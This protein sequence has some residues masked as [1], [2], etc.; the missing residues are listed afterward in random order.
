VCTKSSTQVGG[1]CVSDCTGGAATC[2]TGTSCKP[3]W[4]DGK[5]GCLGSGSI[6][7]CASA[8]ATGNTCNYCGTNTYFT[9]QCN[10]ASGSYTCPANGTCAGNK[11]CNCA[12]GFAA[13]NCSNTLCSSIGGCQAPNWWCK[14][15]TNPTPTCNDASATTSETCQC[16]DGRSI[17]LCALATGS[18]EYFCSTGCDVVQQGCPVASGKCTLL[19]DTTTNTVV[20]GCAPPLNAGTGTEGASCTRAS[21]N[22]T[23]VGHDDCAKGFFCTQIGSP[24]GALKC[25]KLCHSVSNCSAG[26]R[27]FARDGRTP[28]D[29]TCVATCNLFQACTNGLQC[30]SVAIDT[31]TVTW[32]PICRTAGAN[33]LGM[34]CNADAD[35]AAGMFCGHNHASPTINVCTPLCDNSHACPATYS[36]VPLTGLPNGGGYC[37]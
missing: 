13:V 22:A 29:G 27:C 7:A 35:C 4:H 11:T 34:G 10:D 12:T 16:T 31:D 9:V 6:A 33:T 24:D 17:P 30:A 37:N 26:Q 8:V 28:E 20:P 5:S 1:V 32:F 3:L 15:N 2:A 23:D 21:S 18:C 14:A 19:A 25:Q 36:C